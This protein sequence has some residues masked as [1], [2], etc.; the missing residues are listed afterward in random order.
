[1][2]ARPIVLAGID[3]GRSSDWIWVC[4]YHIPSKT[5]KNINQLSDNVLREVLFAGDILKTDI[6]DLLLEYKVKFGLIDNEPDIDKAA[7]I[8]ENTCLEM[9]DQKTGQFEEYKLATVV[10]GGIEYSCW[11]IRNEKFLK[12]VQT[13]FITPFTDGGSLI[14]LPLEWERWY[15]D[16]SERSPFRHLKALEYKPESGK[17]ERPNDHIDDIYFA[18]SFSEAAFYIY[19]EDKISMEQYIEGYLRQ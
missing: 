16:N 17:W 4:R 5:Y 2:E 19:M 15:G 18:A 13:L 11:K 1:M 10:D 7:R 8:C 3:C 14:R 12:Q 6:K 9:A